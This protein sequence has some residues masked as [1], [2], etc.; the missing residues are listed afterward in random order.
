[1]KTSRCYFCQK[2]KP[3]SDFWRDRTR[4]SGVSTACKRC[5]TVRRGIKDAQHKIN[6]GQKSLS[7]WI[8]IKNKILKSLR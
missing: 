8:G 6:E 3:L 5:W 1:M 4:S 7:K 2:H